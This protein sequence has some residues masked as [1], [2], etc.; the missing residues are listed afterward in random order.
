MKCRY[1]AS[2][3]SALA[4]LC[5]DCGSYQDKWRTEL[6]FWSSIV[7]LVALIVTGVTF[8][9]D[10]GRDLYQKLFGQSLAISDISTTDDLRVWNISQTDIW[11]TEVSC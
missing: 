11:I 2:E 10:L 5:S 1:C 9:F 3:I 7:G 4:K 8:S 6:K